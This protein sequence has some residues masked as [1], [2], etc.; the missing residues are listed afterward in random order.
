MRRLLA[1]L[2]GILQMSVRI[3]VAL[4]NEGTDVWRPLSAVHIRNDVYRITG[5]PAADEM[6]EFTAGD[7]VR[8][9]ERRFTEGERQLVA[10]ARASE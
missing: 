6:V 3:Y 8:C 4:L 7:I 9:Q 2:S 5:L 1:D 10:I